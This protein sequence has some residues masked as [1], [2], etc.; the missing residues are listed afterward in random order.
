MCVSIAHYRSVIGMHDNYIKTKENKNICLI[1]GMLR[2]VFV[3]FGPVVLKILEYDNFSYCLVA[4]MILLLKCGDVESNPGPPNDLNCTKF[5]HI[6]A[7]SLLSDTNKDLH[8][9]SQYS[10]LDDIYETLV[11]DF[12]FDIIGICETWLDNQIVD[13]SLDLY[14]YHTPLTRHR[15]G[16]GGGVMLYVKREFSV[17]RRDD[18]ELDNIEL[19]WAEVKIGKQKILF[20]VGYRPPGMSSVQVDEFL[21]LFS[22]SYELALNE[23]SDA[24]II[25]GDFNDTCRK[26]D[27]DHDTSE[28][29]LK[30][31]NLLLDYNLFQLI[32][33]PTR[34]LSLLD[35]VITDSPGYIMQCSTLPPIS[36]IDH[37]II[38]GHLSIHN[39]LPSKVHRTVWHY[40]SANFE[41]INRDLET[42]PWGTAFETFGC[43][44][45]EILNF[46]YEIIY[47]VMDEH[48]P[49]RNIIIKK[50]DKPWMTPHVRWSIRLRN[51][52]NGTYD[53][54]LDPYHKLMRNFIRRKCKK[55]IIHAKYIYYNRLK[56]ELNSD[57]ITAKRYW[58][59]MKELYGSK[60]KETI[61]TLIDDDEIF[62]SDLAKANLF[63]EFFAETCSLPPPP[64]NF[65]LPPVTY[66]T[67]QRLSTIDFVPSDIRKLLN[68]LNVSKASGPDNVSNRFLKECSDSLAE[69]L[70]RFFKLSMSLSYFPDKW[71]ESNL[72]PVYKKSLKHCKSNYRP[73]SLL[74]CVSKIMGR[75]VFN[76]LYKFFKDTS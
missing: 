30:F 33:E 34:F 31:F 23:P 28:M 75:I 64:P 76:G 47:S 72:S 56:K 32:N 66:R 16:R 65:S 18:L 67:E 49:K 70:C 12:S 29:G 19:L 51:R 35:L 6:N 52:W 5:C 7:R 71:K 11:F 17:Q 26:W 21:D 73:I 55:A 20:A 54:T 58:S 45:D 63:S 38:F 3:F 10:L 8:F 57:E 43:D 1:M 61:P 13:E 27:D 22:Q 74:C 69:P 24:I 68:K 37:R 40:G 36:N 50:H 39:S 59:I 46:Y 44:L 9:D 2:D 42:A 15:G 25:L 62:S 53:R 48:I 14:G 60:V 41:K 4:L